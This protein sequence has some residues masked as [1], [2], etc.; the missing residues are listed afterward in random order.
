[1]RCEARHATPEPPKLLYQSAAAMCVVKRR[2]MRE[3][4][5]NALII[6][7]EQEDS[8]L[9]EEFEKGKKKK[10]TFAKNPK[11]PGEKV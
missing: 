5:M 9:K 3:I 1:L 8:C 11:D 2:A 7:L 6:E 4:V 10:N